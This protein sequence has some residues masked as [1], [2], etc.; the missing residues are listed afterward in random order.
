MVMV[1]T[2]LFI[3]GVLFAEMILGTPDI[4]TVDQRTRALITHRM[5]RA[6]PQ[7]IEEALRLAALAEYCI[8]R[9][10]TALNEERS[11]S[12]D[13][14]EIELPM[15]IYARVAGVSQKYLTPTVTATC[16]M[17]T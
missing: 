11:P 4:F 1:M 5:R 9:H 17:I 10:P 14:R 6:D 16:G 13:G 7:A 15:R 8:Y 12:A 3:L 2:D